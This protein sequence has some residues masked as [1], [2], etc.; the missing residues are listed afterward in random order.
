M[1]EVNLRSQEAHVIGNVTKIKQG[2]CVI[3]YVFP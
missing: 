2:K 3:Q 1:S